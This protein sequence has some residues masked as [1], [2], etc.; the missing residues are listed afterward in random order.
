MNAKERELVNQFLKKFVGTTDE[1]SSVI[2]GFRE[3]PLA[4][5]F[6]APRMNQA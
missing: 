3:N 1:G 6:Q 4:G 2:R 5:T